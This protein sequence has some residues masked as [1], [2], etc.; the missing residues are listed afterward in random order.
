MT[1]FEF[2][3]VSA[4]VLFGAGVL[5]RLP[6]EASRLGSRHFILS[7]PGQRELAV[8]AAALLGEKAACIHAEAVSHV[9]ADIADAAVVAAKGQQV[10]AIVAIGGGS[11]I[12][13]AKIVALRLNLPILAVATTYAG[14]EM[15]PVWGLTTD[16]V[17]RTG[18]DPLVQPKTVLYDPELTYRLPPAISVVSGINAIAHCVEA[19][20]SETANPLTTLMAEEGIR[21]LSVSLPPIVERPDDIEARAGALY[22]AWM[23]GSVLGSVGMALH[24]K[25]CHTLGGAFNLPH[26]ETHA[27]V[28]P[29]VAAY[30]RGAAPEA[31][32]RIARALGVADAPTGLFELVGSVGAKRALRDIGMPESGIERTVD[33]TLANPYY[34][35][36]PLA[37]PHLLRLV[38]NAYEGRPPE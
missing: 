7:T 20:Y 12:G 6:K 2:E 13:L 35:P 11:A 10:D 25:L 29:H 1:P 38:R 16:G 5:A 28:L 31:M 8:R 17:K 36:A 24:H 23:A 9:P 32:R 34:N 15:T 19:L 21:A 26:A 22:G 27:I 37:R 18:R 30:N 4:R 33:L 3:S 14:S